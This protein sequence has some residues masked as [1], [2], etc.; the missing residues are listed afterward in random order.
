V[1]DILITCNSLWNI[2]C[3]AGESEKCSAFHFRLWAW[4]WKRQLQ[5]QL[6]KSQR[7][8]SPEVMPGLTNA[9]DLAFCPPP[10]GKWVTY[11][12]CMQASANSCRLSLYVRTSVPFPGCSYQNLTNIFLLWHAQRLPFRSRQEP[13]SQI[14]ANFSLEILPTKKMFSYIW[15]Y[16]DF[17]VLRLLKGIYSSRKILIHFSCFAS[18]F[19]FCSQFSAI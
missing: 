10:P 18:V 19:Y 11:A 9:P 16:G 13:W 6:P 5:L 1:T 14:W 8:I 4:K 15:I 7:T 2:F 12:L 17:K 3:H